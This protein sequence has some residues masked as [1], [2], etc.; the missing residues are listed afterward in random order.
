MEARFIW[1]FWPIIKLTPLSR[2][3]IRLVCKV[4]RMD[5]KGER[6]SRGLQYIS[7]ESWEIVG[8]VTILSI[9]W[10]IS[11]WWSAEK[12]A[13]DNLITNHQLVGWYNERWLGLGGDDVHVISVWGIKRFET[14]ETQTGKG[15]FELAMKDW[16]IIGI[17]EF[18]GS[19]RRSLCNTT[20]T[21][22]RKMNANKNCQ[23]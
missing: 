14:N 7:H 16:R 4:P 11:G 12:S 3:L 20:Q 19:F 6:E 1:W 21:C 15:W 13:A 5:I 17:L 22:A 10:E 9:S 8:C 18:C 23:I 2:I